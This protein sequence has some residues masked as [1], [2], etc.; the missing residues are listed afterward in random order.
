M[1]LLPLFEIANVHVAGI[2]L[3]FTKEQE[4]I[5]NLVE[6]K[7]KTKNYKKIWNSCMRKIILNKSCIFHE[8]VCAFFL[9]LPKK[10]KF[11]KSFI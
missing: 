2:I 1:G 4:M 3:Y 11:I 8:Y 5:L 7:K 9:L 6:T 10:R